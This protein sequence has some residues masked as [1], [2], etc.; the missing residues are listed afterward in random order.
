MWLQEDQT[1]LFSIFPC[2]LLC[3]L[4]V[5]AFCDQIDVFVRYASNELYLMFKAWI[6]NKQSAFDYNQ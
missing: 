4:K 1:I 5:I 2:D 6:R 3:F